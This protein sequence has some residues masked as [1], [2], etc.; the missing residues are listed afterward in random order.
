MS[1][2]LD[3]HAFIWFVA[4]DQRLSSAATAAIREEP[5]RVFVS[6]A[7]VWEIG[8]K[9]STGK[10]T[11]DTSLADMV[12][13]MGEDEMELLPIVPSHVYRA[14]SLAFHHR[15]PFDR[16]LVA[17]ALVDDL[18]IISVDS[19]LVAYGIRRLW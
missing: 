5:D 12:D 19:Q 4:A 6:I 16:M 15:D 13:G 1:L 8:I 2:L 3:T 17:Q 11:L 7:R 9:H 10:L 18:T 14:A